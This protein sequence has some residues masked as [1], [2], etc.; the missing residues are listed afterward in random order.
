MSRL[1]GTRKEV[2][3]DEGTGEKDL[4]LTE[5]SYERKRG[6]RMTIKRNVIHAQS[7]G[8]RLFI[9][10]GYTAIYIGDAKENQCRRRLEILTP[11]YNFKYSTRLT[12]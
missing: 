1:E 5:I 7:K 6:K 2:I 11:N 4:V 10:I 3:G 8:C 12:D 9:Q